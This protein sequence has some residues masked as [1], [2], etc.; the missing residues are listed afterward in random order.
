MEWKVKPE[1]GRRHFNTYVYVC[2]DAYP[3]YIKNS[4]KSVGK[5]KKTRLHNRKNGQGIWEG[6]SYKRL[7]QMTNKHEHVLNFINHE[8]NASENLNEI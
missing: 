7:I 2:L 8:G 3:E 1:C 4:Y 5:K 6:T